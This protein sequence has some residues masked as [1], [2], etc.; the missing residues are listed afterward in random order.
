MQL[1][2]HFKVELLLYKNKQCVHLNTAS[3]CLTINIRSNGTTQQMYGMI[4]SSMMS[5]LW[6]WSSIWTKCIFSES[7]LTNINTTSYKKINNSKR[8]TIRLVQSSRSDWTF[9]C[10]AWLHLVSF[11]FRSVSISVSCLK[12]H[13]PES[14][15][16]PAGPLEHTPLCVQASVFLVHFSTL[17]FGIMLWR[18]FGPLPSTCA[19]NPT[20]SGVR[21][22]CAGQWGA[23][24]EA[25]SLLILLITG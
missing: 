3:V 5:E 1:Q 20:L 7:L 6:K 24:S 16:S 23:G 2:S 10:W 15:S 14:V 12:R 19:T 25:F 21:C 8:E 11:R 22:S 4:R 13:Q 18:R 17:W 9:R